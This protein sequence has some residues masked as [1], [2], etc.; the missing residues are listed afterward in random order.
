MKLRK[1]EEVCFILLVILFSYS[2]NRLFF[3]T[4]YGNRLTQY[5]YREGMEDD[6]DEVDP[7][8][9]INKADYTN[10]MKSV[11]KF[12]FSKKEHGRRFKKMLRE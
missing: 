11:R 10:Q 9:D 5:H 8:Y 12:G 7:D 4:F 3:H 6:S 2:V 1:Y